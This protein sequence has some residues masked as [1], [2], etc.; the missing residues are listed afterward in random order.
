MADTVRAELPCPY[1]GLE[2]FATRQAHLFFGRERETRMVVNNLFA[3][4]LTL[5][6]GPSGV[7]KSSLLRAGVMARLAREA[8][9]GERPE[10][11]VVYLNRWQDDV[12]THFR[13]AVESAVCEALPEAEM[14]SAVV[15][16]EGTSQMAAWL[17]AICEEQGI[18]LLLLFDQ[19]EEFFLYH[20]E[21]DTAGKAFARELAAAVRTR[22][23][24]AHFLLGLRDD[25][26]ARLDRFKVLIPNLFSNY[27]RL[28]P[29]S[30]EAAKAAIL[31]PLAVLNA[32]TDA[33]VEVE[34]ALVETVLAQVRRSVVG[35]GVGGEGRVEGA[36]AGIEA[37][38]L[39]LVMTRIW[40]EEQG[41]GSS[42]LR[43]LTF[44]ERLGGAKMIVREHLGRV[45]AKLSEEEKA[46]CARMFKY[47]V[48]PSG[49]KIAHK[50]SDLGKWAE[51]P[52]EQTERLLERLM[53][54]GT[55]VLVKV[56]P[57]DAS[58]GQERYEIYHD[59]L[60]EAM[61]EWQQSWV[62]QEKDAEIS[63]WRRMV[64][65][66]VV[67]MGVALVAFA[68][69]FRMKQLA[70]EK[71]AE[72]KDLAAQ[73]TVYAKELQD[74]IDEKALSEEELVKLRTMRASLD[75]IEA[76]IGSDELKQITTD[77]DVQ[78]KRADDAEAELA[79]VHRELASVRGE[80]E[81]A[82]AR[83]RA[84]AFQPGD[85][86]VEPAIGMRFRS[87]PA[88][89]FTMG[90]PEDEPGHD[91]S[92]TQH[93]VTLTRSFWMGETEVTQGQWRAVMGNNPSHFGR[94]GDECPVERVSWWDAVTYA[95]RLSEKAGL[96]SCYE[97]EGCSGTPGAEGYRCK[98]AQILRDSG[99]VG[100]RL[101][102]EAEW[103]HAARAGMT[104]VLT[105]TE[106]DA[107]AWHLNNSGYRTHPVGG[108]EVNP[109]G[110]FDML[111]NVSEWCRD[112]YG[113][114]TAEPAIDPTGPVEGVQR[115]LRGNSWGGV[116][117]NVNAA[118]RRRFRPGIRDSRSGFRLAR[119]QSALKSGAERLG[120]KCSPPSLAYPITLAANAIRHCF[121]L[122]RPP[123]TRSDT[124][125]RSRARR[126]RDQTPICA[127]APAANA[128]R[129]RF[130]LS[131]PPRTRLG[132][133]TIRRSHRDG[134]SISL[135]EI[136][137]GARA[138]I[139]GQTRSRP[140]R[141]QKFFARRSRVGRF[142][143]SASRNG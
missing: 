102:T 100:F 57:T 91:V 23:L 26:L 43:A 128:I 141:H 87:I 82:K 86:W 83:I 15:S 109:W 19:F 93:R 58:G 52:A 47:L 44:L 138:E 73:V 4:R 6:Y 115:V 120:G 34:E 118:A 85:L 41:A 31:K 119:G 11:V 22:G 110:L 126:E 113:N 61:L 97:L 1:V 117:F 137:A 74:A 62:K 40:E 28:E 121:A 140:P 135:N 66:L 35:A 106:L 72:A 89:T 63:K 71:A 32:E 13:E 3:S 67:A 112:W 7:G 122:S 20:P 65:G 104:T 49:T 30:N 136:S 75:A 131:R 56:A 14:P 92:E 24:A 134:Q 16:S 33:A 114:Y 70:D 103:E 139:F 8:V 45:M 125:L 42:R 12:R 101:P 9:E 27:L 59:A 5:L 60:G 124:D 55:R 108:K 69:A 79:S 51:V 37:P 76:T 77:R 95:N 25:A 123:R 88:G 78:K 107:I 96:E 38:Y 21:D 54:T 143:T 130:L 68:V 18:D 99:C 50:A 98:S 10:H 39:Q 90:S 29:L 111:G 142:G 84:L 133:S 36:Q 94:C 129:Q 48:T 127:L 116:A 81:T 2:P 17:G 80:L 105:G 132:E 46:T 64:A 53:G